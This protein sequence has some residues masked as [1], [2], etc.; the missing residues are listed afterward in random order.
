MA[1]KFEEMSIEELQAFRLDVA[2]KIDTQKKLFKAAGQ[3][4]D[5]K[6]SQTPEAKAL[7]K[8]GEAR[9][10]LAIIRAEEEEAAAEEGGN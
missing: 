3:V 10:E 8:L 5:V 1:D 9:E 4:L 7:K 6:L 2:A